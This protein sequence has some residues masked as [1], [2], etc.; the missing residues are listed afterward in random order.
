[1]S[2]RQG[3]QRLSASE[4]EEHRSPEPLVGKH[5]WTV[6]QAPWI[7]VIANSPNGLI[8]PTLPGVLPMKRR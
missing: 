3:A 1:M 7:L 2:T 4:V 6:L 5:P 8:S